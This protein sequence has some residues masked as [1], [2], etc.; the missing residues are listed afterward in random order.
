M[1][2]V[3]DTPFLIVPQVSSERREYVP[4]GWLEPPIIPSEK[5][6][7]LTGATF[8]DDV[9]VNGEVTADELAVAPGGVTVEGEVVLTTPLGPL[10][11]G[12]PEHAVVFLAASA[13]PDGWVTHTDAQGRYV[14][15]VLDGGTLAGTAGTP[16]SD[17]EARAAGDHS[18]SFSDSFNLSH[19]HSFS[20]A[21]TISL[22]HR[23]SFSDAH[24]HSFSAT[25][26]NQSANHTHAYTRPGSPTMRIFDAGGDHSALISSSSA[27]SSGASVG[28]N[29][30]LSGTTGS[31][32]VSGDTGTSG[33][34]ETVNIS[35]TTGSGGG[36]ETVSGTTGPGGTSTTPAPYL[37]LLACRRVI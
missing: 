19:N 5:L 29:H 36:A 18:H 1:T 9:Q 20:D 25:T 33:G 23:H 22:G 4:I 37:Q 10:S 35:G 31:R 24:T 28:H 2:T 30:N 15:G 6:R 26:I 27:T 12:V 34:S 3:P 7:L 14:V 13:C 17:L 32:T 11:G 8:G 21:D 16:L